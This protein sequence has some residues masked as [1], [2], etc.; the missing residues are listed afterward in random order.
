M[1]EL[2]VSE[3][4]AVSFGILFL[5]G[6]IFAY[7]RQK[8]LA[9]IAKDWPI[10]SARVVERNL[11]SNDPS[12]YKFLVEYS[13]DGKIFR[14]IVQNYFAIDSRNTHVGELIDIKV[15]PKDKT[16]CTIREIIG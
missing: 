15:D 10:Y 2:Y 5:C 6:A 16:R 7:V 12:G 3:I 11:V 9:R 4:I 14:E 8:G 1:R 13:I